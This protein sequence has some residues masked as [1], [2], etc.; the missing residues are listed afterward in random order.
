MSAMVIAYQI[1]HRGHNAPEEAVK[2]HILPQSL[3]AGIVLQ[4]RRHAINA[5]SVDMSNTDSLRTT[6]GTFMRLLQTYQL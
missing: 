2:V 6:C 5:Y 1:N 3:N 4:H